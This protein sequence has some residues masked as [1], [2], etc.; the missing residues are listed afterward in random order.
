MSTTKSEVLPTPPSLIRSLLAGFDTISNH[1]SL[2]FFSVMLDLLLWFGPRISLEKFFLPIFTPNAAVSEMQSKE[3]IEVLQAAIQEF[4]LLSTLRTFPVGI[5]SLLASRVPLENPSGSIYVWE[6]QSLG[7]AFLLWF[8]LIIIGIGAGTLYFATV[9]QA[10]LSDKVDWRNTLSIW[11]W[12]CSQVL[13]LTVAWFI[14][15]IALIVPF[16]CMF[17]M[18]LLFGFGVQQITL[19]VALIVIGLLVWMLI[20]LVFSP[21]GI[22]VNRRMMWHSIRD[23]IRLTRLTL[24]TTS[25][26]FL[27]IVILSEGLNIL[28]NVPED[29][30]WWFLVGIVG[31]AFVTSG[32]LAASFVYYRDADRW[33]QRILQQAKFSLA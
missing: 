10:A 31:H 14:L 26:L 12:A 11:P 22:F 19:V 23:S 4:N 20:P 8:F 7:F 9:A 17:S 3:V 13:L 24:P 28:W 27:T 21:H 25:L 6:P 16:S 2:I 32:L 5:P 33:I 18:F 30:S 29:K 1:I 15:L